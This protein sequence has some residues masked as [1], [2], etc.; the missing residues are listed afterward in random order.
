MQCDQSSNVS[1]PVSQRSWVRIPFSPEV[2][3]RLNF[4]TAYAVRITAVISHAFI[5]ISFMIFHIFT[6]S[7]FISVASRYNYNA[8]DLSFFPAKTN[9][10][11]ANDLFVDT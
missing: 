7:G 10:L 4:S 11:V 5:S 9:H 6:C 3:L 2:S 1:T 8:R